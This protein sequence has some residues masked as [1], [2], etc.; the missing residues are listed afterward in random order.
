M[1]D[2]YRKMASER[3]SAESKFRG[4]SDEAQALRSELLSTD[5]D[6]KRCMERISGLEK[7]VSDHVR[8]INVSPFYNTRVS[9]GT[10]KL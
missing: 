6:R 5:S 2:Q 1:L 7:D 4:S 9:P 8:V 10:T 3:D